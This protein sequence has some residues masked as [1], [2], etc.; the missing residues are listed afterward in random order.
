MTLP[1]PEHYFPDDVAKHATANGVV[2]VHVDD[3]KRWQTKMQD[4]FDLGF[5][6]AGGTMIPDAAKNWSL[7]EMALDRATIDALAEAAETVLASPDDA[8]DFEKEE[9]LLRQFLENIN[10]YRRRA[11]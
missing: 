5:K 6:A 2:A 7:V 4:A 11:K 8:P 9:P 10:I 1:W 3:L